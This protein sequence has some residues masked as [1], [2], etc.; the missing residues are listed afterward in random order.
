M[1]YGREIRQ[2]WKM[3]NQK[4]KLFN[5]WIGLLYEKKTNLLT[6]K[7]NIYKQWKKE[8]MTLLNIFSDSVIF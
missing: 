6:L 2:P 5:L 3:K 1:I 7:R 8:N 4:E